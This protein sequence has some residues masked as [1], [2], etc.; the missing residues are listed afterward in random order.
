MKDNKNSN[1]IPILGI[2][3]A[4][5]LSLVFTFIKT[6]NVFSKNKIPTEAFKVY[7]KGE[8]IGLINSDQEL[9]DYINKMQEELMKKYNVNHV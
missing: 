8:V 4:I 2:I 3:I 7:L 5:I 9:Y 6:N 1:N